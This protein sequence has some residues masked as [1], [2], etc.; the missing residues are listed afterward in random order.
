MIYPNRQQF[1]L[2][3]TTIPLLALAAYEISQLFKKPE[4]SIAV[5]ILSTSIIVLGFFLWFNI[6]SLA[7]NN[8]LINSQEFILQIA[9]FAIVI[10]LMI[11][12]TL[13]V[14]C[15]MV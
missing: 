12:G 2:L 11:L 5:L 9:I 7:R 15:W 1:D 8:Y 13:M 10:V 4:N 14:S 6:S 3:W